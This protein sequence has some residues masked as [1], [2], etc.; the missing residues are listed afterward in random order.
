[1]YRWKNIS[2]SKE[3]EEGGVVAEVDICE[4]EV[5]QRTLAGK[6]WTDINFNVRAFTSTMLSS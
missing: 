4:E 3:E 5:F 6:L 1:M 2:L